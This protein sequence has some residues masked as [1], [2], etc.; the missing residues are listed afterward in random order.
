MT[1]TAISGPPARTAG[2]DDC[3]TWRPQGLDGPLPGGERPAGGAWRALFGGPGPRAV[4]V[5][6]PL[7]D[8]VP[9]GLAGFELRAGVWR[10]PAR[11]RAARYTPLAG[12]HRPSARPVSVVP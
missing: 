12:Q 9:V 11:R 10:P 7:P 8:P 2:S 4:A 1:G 3:A 6:S 5:V